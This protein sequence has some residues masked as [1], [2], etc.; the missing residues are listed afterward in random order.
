MQVC[1]RK[2]PTGNRRAQSRLL[3][4]QEGVVVILGAPAEARHH[5]YGRV[6]GPFPRGYFT[7]GSCD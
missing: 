5:G 2:L 4:Q 7:A 1:G 3:T 6:V